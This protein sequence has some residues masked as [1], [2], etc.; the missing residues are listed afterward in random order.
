MNDGLV[1]LKWHDF[2]F[3]VNFPLINLIHWQCSQQ[4]KISYLYLMSSGEYFVL[5]LKITCGREHRKIFI[6]Y[7]HD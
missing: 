5:A 3:L 7:K 2:I 4:N 1:G 6:I